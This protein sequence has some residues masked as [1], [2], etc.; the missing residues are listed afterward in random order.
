MCFQEDGTP[1]EEGYPSHNEESILDYLHVI[2]PIA[3][4]F[5]LFPIAS[6]VAKVSYDNRWYFQYRM[7]RWKIARESR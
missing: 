5:V 1:L 3:A 6:I 2:V 7:A 4:V